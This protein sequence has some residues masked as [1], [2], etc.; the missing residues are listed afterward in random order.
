MCQFYVYQNGA[1]LNF[2]MLI[3]SQMPL[4]WCTIIFYVF[5]RRFLATNKS[6]KEN[7]SLIKRW[8][9]FDQVVDKST[10]KVLEKYVSEII[11]H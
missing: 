9:A 7:F 5:L 3:V 11:L 10:F 2:F 4:T 8:E 1:D 6:G